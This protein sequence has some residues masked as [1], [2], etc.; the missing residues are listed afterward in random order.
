MARLTR[1]QVE[2]IV[3]TRPDGVSEQDAIRGIIDRGYEIEGLSG[4][5][6]KQ[7]QTPLPGVNPGNT[8][9]STSAV[10]GAEPT[11][12]GK[13]GQA[14][15]RTPMRIASSLQAGAE[16]V[17]AGFSDD[18]DLK[19][20]Q[21]RNIEGRDYGLLGKNIRPFGYQASELQQR[22]DQGENIGAT[23]VL[24]TGGRMAA[25]IGG[26]QAEIASYGMA[27]LTITGRGFTG[28]K[29]LLKGTAG[30]SSLVAGSSV[31][32]SIDQGDSIGETVG[33]AAGSYV[34][35]TATF[36]M[37]RFAGNLF[38][39]RGATLVQDDALRQSSSELNVL[40]EDLAKTNPELLDPAF[41]SNP[42]LMQSQ[43]LSSR[44]RAFEEKFN[45]RMLTI[46]N[47]S[48]DRLLPKVDDPAIVNHDVYL[49]I[50]N[51]QGA[52]F[53]SEIGSDA[54]YEFVRRQQSKLPREELT[55]TNAAIQKA[56]QELDARIKA[57]AD[58]PAAMQ[59][60]IEQSE[61]L[62][63][64]L[65]SIGRQTNDGLGIPG[66]LRVM[67][68]SYVFMDGSKAD[69]A[70]IRGIIGAV[71]DDLRQGLPPEDVMMWDRAHNSWQ[72]ATTLYEDATLN[73]IKNSGFGDDLVEGLMSS[74]PGPSRDMLFQTLNNSNVKP[75]V[76]E[77]LL[78]TAMRRA[79]Q[80]SNAEANTYLRNFRNS[81]YNYE[82]GESYLNSQQA[83]VLDDF[84]D[85]T[86]QSFK[87]T[88]YDMQNALDLTPKQYQEIVR[89]FDQLDVFK[90]LT[91]GNADDM[92]KNFT[93]MMEREP[94][95]V[96]RIIGQFDDK[97][98]EVFGMFMMRDLM[99]R[100]NAAIVPDPKNPSRMMISDGFMDTYEQTYKTIV[101]S[102]MRTGSDDIYRMFSQ[103]ELASLQRGYEIL[104]DVRVLETPAQRE[105]AQETIDAVTAMLY[106]KMGYI[107]GAARYVERAAVGGGQP[108]VAT[109]KQIQE[110][111]AKYLQEGTE[112][113]ELPMNADMPTRID[114]LN[115]R[116]GTPAVGNITADEEDNQPQE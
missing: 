2:K 21:R 20:V 81:V 115:S 24:K 109:R 3:S 25:D 61:G 92:A 8:S 77:L 104:N 65:T 5:A 19:D 46:R 15:V 14:V 78:N 110:T 90:E 44:A 40:M 91:G 12:V 37:M 114:Y 97:E 51:Q 35:S 52:M 28:F 83:G 58:D 30:V 102:Q 50:A 84:V 105:T 23:D 75:R 98:R 94:E 107:T 11:F 69:T 41:V 33:R 87:D 106:A 18:F 42:R 80:M 1:E 45:E 101:E 22:R 67:E 96:G 47:Q 38:R 31:G 55:K 13:F 76:Q 9:N 73:Q 64:F 27:P 74:K 7:N 100:R 108:R 66:A 86:S 88:V 56:Q 93:T 6:P 39:N 32:Q 72:R 95:K 111:A 113:G 103:E 17:A 59:R 116:F 60:A 36:G 63:A 99:T 82:T 29:N 112:N 57:S 48:I 71:R 34:A 70:A 43:L 54:M 26:G 10:G 49:G 89:D 79:K 62:S 4:S 68:D 53:K 16:G 85:F